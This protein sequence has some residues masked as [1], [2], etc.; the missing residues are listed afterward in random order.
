MFSDLCVRGWGFET[1]VAQP[2][3]LKPQETSQKR[4]FFVLIVPKKI[5]VRPLLWELQMEFAGF[6]RVF[7]R[8]QT[9]L[10]CANSD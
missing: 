10:F 3:A 8:T 2:P 4:S 1:N 5:M 9:S 7:R 6:P